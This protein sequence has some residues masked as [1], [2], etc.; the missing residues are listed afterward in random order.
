M[1]YTLLSSHFQVCW[2]QYFGWRHKRCLDFVEYI[3]RRFGCLLLFTV[4]LNLYVLFG[5][6]LC[7]ARPFS[8]KVEEIFVCVQPFVRTLLPWLSR[9]DF[10]CK[11]LDVFIVSHLPVVHFALRFF[12]KGRSRFHFSWSLYVLHRLQ[13]IVV[14]NLPLLDPSHDDPLYDPSYERK[15]FSDFVLWGAKGQTLSPCFNSSPKI[16]FW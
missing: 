11:G 13:S 5:G 4:S 7:N 9:Q 10:C 3:W 14:D 12:V 8:E 15:N 16:F 6:S 1:V 2:T